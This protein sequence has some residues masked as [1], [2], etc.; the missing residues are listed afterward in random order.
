MIFQDVDEFLSQITEWPLKRK[1]ISLVATGG[2]FDLLQEGHV[3]C[4][5]AAKK[6]GNN[7]VVL[8]NTDESVR[9]NR[10]PKRP[11]KS[12][13][14]RA[15]ILDALES[16]DFVIFFNEITPIEALDKL[17][18][19]KWVKGGDYNIETLPE[20]EVVEKHGG[21]II[22]FPRIGTLST[23]NIIKKIL[24]THKDEVC[25]KCNLKNKGLVP[26]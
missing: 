14:Q 8:L 26:K 13:K 25:A 17:K 23:T 1:Y 7:L 22:I 19:D 21:K 12:Q 6:L 3:E 2:V 18:C 5:K 10:G 16:V 20:K 15:I 24:K 4:L 9:K 11:I